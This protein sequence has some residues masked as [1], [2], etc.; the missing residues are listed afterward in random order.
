MPQNIEIE[1]KNMLTKEEYLRLLTDFQID[2]INIFFQENHYFDTK[3]FALKDKG[4]A[5]RIR[6]KKNSWEMTLKQPAEIGLLETN[7]ILS[8]REA[9]EAIQFGRLPLGQ[10]KLIIEEMGI[11]FGKLVYFG[12]L[13]TRRAEAAFKKGVLVFDHNIYL[14]QEDFELEYEVENF[15]EGQEVFLQL[16]K[17]YQI[18]VRKTENKIRRFYRQKYNL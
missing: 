16:L 9:L 2:E 14:N 5:L 4:S 7:Q 12:S 10:I 6:L 17:N 15:Q 1:F 18:P 13:A 3:E 8:E 11:P